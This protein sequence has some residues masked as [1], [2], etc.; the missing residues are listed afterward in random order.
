MAE[1][2]LGYIR[3]NWLK[4]IVNL[5]SK[6]P[7]SKLED[8]A[9]QSRL[10]HLRLRIGQGLGLSNPF[11]ASQRFA[12]Q[13]ASVKCPPIIWRS[14]LSNMHGLAQDRLRFGKFPAAKKNL[15]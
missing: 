2:A 5:M 9:R 3:C 1:T 6:Y 10:C 7:R 11:E 14:F 13:V 8:K 12:K 4:A 15:P